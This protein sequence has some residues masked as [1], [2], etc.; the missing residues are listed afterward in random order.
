MR[1]NTII[2]I[3]LLLMAITLAGVIAVIRLYNLT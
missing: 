3:S 1:K 2:A